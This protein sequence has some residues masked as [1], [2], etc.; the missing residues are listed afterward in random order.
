M[1]ICM[2]C[3]SALHYS[4]PNCGTPIRAGARFCDSCGAP[5]GEFEA[6]SADDIPTSRIVWNAILGFIVAFAL[7]YG[8]ISATDWILT[9]PAASSVPFL[10]IRSAQA[11]SIAQTYVDS[12]FSDFSQAERS[13]F[14][15]YVDNQPVY[16]VDFVKFDQPQGLRVLVSRDLS[17]VWVYQLVEGN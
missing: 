7:I 17:A 1:L 11:G 12:Y 2:S 8:A 13:V 14:P 10:G 3:G 5:V 15:A 9:T 4:C 6:D 16:V